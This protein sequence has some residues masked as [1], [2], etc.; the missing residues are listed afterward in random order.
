MKFKL[1][2]AAP[3][4]F[5]ENL[6]LDLPAVDRMMNHHAAL[7]V[8]GVMLG[9]TCGE[10]PWM[11]VEDLE[12]LVT[13]ASAHTAGRFKIAA[14]ITDNS[15]ERMLHHIERMA[16]AG[17]DYAV[18]AAPYFM[19]N[20]TPER[21]LNVYRETIEKSVLP[22]VCYDRGAGD[23]Y[24]LTVEQLPELFA[25]KNMGMIKD[26]SC[27]AE[28]AAAR[29]AAQQNRPD[30]AVLCGDEFG[31]ADAV[32][33]D[34]NGGFLGGAI[35]N[36]LQAWSILEDIE[37]GNPDRAQATQK[38][39]NDFMFVVYGGPSIS[40]WLTGLKYFLVRLGI[41]STTASYLEYPLAADVRAEIDLLF[42]G[43][44]REELIE[45]LLAGKK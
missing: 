29:H 40:A 28:R 39:M 16:D 44:Q 13:R 30:V 22:V 45:P 17:A 25:L 21:I 26:S 35:F 8:D 38:R 19:M 33:G 18:I 32:I 4:P 23:R 34:M 11:P 7:H 15:A 9:G 31:M 20:P 36:A 27:N 6:Q 12:Q 37:A 2:S 24:Q 14:Q 1:W 43:T 42:D 5:T 3:T 41:F 10:G